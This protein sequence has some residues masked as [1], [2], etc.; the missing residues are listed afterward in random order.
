MGSNDTI[1]Y[2]VLVGIM[3]YFQY[4]MQIYILYLFGYFRMLKLNIGI[5]TYKELK[6]EIS[7][8]L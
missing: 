2:E 6:S 5:F 8:E 1:V 3:D 4:N 7:N